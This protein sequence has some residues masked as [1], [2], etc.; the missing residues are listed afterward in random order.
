MEKTREELQEI[1]HFVGEYASML[2]G[3]GVHTLRVVRNVT[4][5][6]NALGV[7]I[8]MSM[9]QTSFVMTVIDRVSEKAYN[10]VISIPHYP[11]NFEFNAELSALSWQAFD[12][13]LDLKEIERRYHLIIQSPRISPF[14]VLGL[15]GIAN[16]SFCKLFAGGWPAV[17]IVLVATLIGFYIRQWMMK[18]HLNHYIVFIVSAFAASICASS[19]LFFST[20]PQTALATSV[21]YLIPGVPLLNG[22][23]DMVSGHVLTGFSRLVNAFLLVLCVAIG[24]S[25]TLL[26]V[27]NNLL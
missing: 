2:M 17:G 12:E 10:R 23:I 18:H 25:F 15:V 19:A 11:I 14:I 22:V 21:L 9:F 16:A 24:L 7:T 5:M 6:G 1:Q 8:N 27:K 3:S 26:L 4:R 20:T 13:K